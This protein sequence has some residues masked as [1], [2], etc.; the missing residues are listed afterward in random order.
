MEH[1]ELYHHG[2]KGMR[3]GVRRYQNKD[4]SL[5]AKGRQRYNEEA[6]KLKAKE[7]ELNTRARTQ[8]K[9]DKLDAKRKELAARE[10]ALKEAERPEIVKKFLEKRQQKAGAKGPVETKGGE[11]R[12]IKDLSD[13]ELNDLVLRMRNEKEYRNLYNDLNPKKVSKGKEF[14]K[15]IFTDS[16]IPG[17][18]EGLKSAIRTAST[19]SAISR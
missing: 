7:K 8:A 10:K 11:K 5:T 15:S 3:W 9:L 17:M 1:N 12:S 19:A 6:E 18:K 2:I 4:G 14:V 16:V 13:K